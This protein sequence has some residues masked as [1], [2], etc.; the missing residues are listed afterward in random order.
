MALNQKVYIT[1]PTKSK[2]IGLNDT[3]RYNTYVYSSL[4]T[5][6]ASNTYIIRS[7]FI[8]IDYALGA[9]AANIQVNLVISGKKISLYRENALTTATASLRFTLEDKGVGDI[10]LV[11]GDTVYVEFIH[12]DATLAPTGNITSLIYLEDYTE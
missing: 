2:T 9:P 6:S 11:T 4:L 8:G 12:N 7:G 3:I 10:R 1:N 5:V